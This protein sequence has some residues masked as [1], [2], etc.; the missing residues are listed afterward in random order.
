M[1]RPGSRRQTIRSTVFLTQGKDYFQAF[2]KKVKP[3]E[4]D[5]F[6][7]G[8]NPRSP[9]QAILDLTDGPGFINIIQKRERRRI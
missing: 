8:S 7:G 3:E 5:L 9:E 1:N 6:A 4:L 2:R